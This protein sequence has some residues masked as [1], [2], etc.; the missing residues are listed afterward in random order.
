MTRDERRT[1]HAAPTQHN[2]VYVHRPSRPTFNLH[3]E[4][5][6][7]NEVDFHSDY[8]R[9]ERIAVRTCLMVIAAGRSGTRA[10]VAKPLTKSFDNLF[11]THA[12][13]P[14]ARDSHHEQDRGASW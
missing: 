1:R 5:D 2:S 14:M 6:W 4:I 13:L 3:L 8:F 7:G 12:M 11:A 9:F 10:S